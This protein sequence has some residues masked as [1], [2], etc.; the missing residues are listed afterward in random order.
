MSKESKIGNVTETVTPAETETVN[1]ETE[2]VNPPAETP[3]PETDAEKI[4]RLTREKNETDAELKRIRF[5]L[6]NA[7]KTKASER[8][9]RPEIIGRVIKNNPGLTRAELEKLSDKAYADAGGKSNPNETKL[10]FSYAEKFF[11]GFGVNVPP[12]VK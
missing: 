9:T 4:E 2:T 5:E 1:A 3:K 8:V 10:Y 11:R 7:K 6:E 12:V